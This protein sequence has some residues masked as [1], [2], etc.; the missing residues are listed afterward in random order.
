MVAGIRFQDQGQSPVHP[1]QH[2][3]KSK[4]SPTWATQSEDAHPQPYAPLKNEALCQ[5][6]KMKIST[7]NISPLLGKTASL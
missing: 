3:L 6:T 1:A 4:G 7:E 5:N 2:L